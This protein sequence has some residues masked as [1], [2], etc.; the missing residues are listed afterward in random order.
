[1]Y[2]GDSPETELEVQSVAQ[3]LLP[4]SSEFIAYLTYHSYGHRIFTCWDYT[5][6]TNPPDHDLAVCGQNC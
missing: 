1:M 3:F 4:R 5:G 6:N 2:M